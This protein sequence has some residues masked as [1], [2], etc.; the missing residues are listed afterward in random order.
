MANMNNT[1]DFYFPCG[2]DTLTWAAQPLSSVTLEVDGVTLFSLG[3]VPYGL[4]ELNDLAPLITD[5]MKT[6]VP[7]LHTLT[8]SLDDGQTETVK[9]YSIVKCR[10]R[11]LQDAP[12]FTERRFLT[13]ARMD[14]YPKY[15]PLDGKEYLYIYTNA[16]SEGV[17]TLAYFT[18]AY[19]NETLG[20]KRVYTT[21]SAAPADG[22]GED[23]TPYVWTFT[24]NDL[25]TQ[26]DRPDDTLSWRLLEVTVRVGLRTAHYVP[27]DR[28]LWDGPVRGF[29]FENA[30]GLIEALWCWGSATRTLKPSYSQTYI[31]GVMTTYDIEAVPTWE[32]QT[33]MFEDGQLPLLDDFLSSPSITRA[34]D[35]VQVVV[36]E[37]NVKT[38]DDY[39]DYHT[40]TFT[41]REAKADAVVPTDDVPG[42][43]VFDDTFDD[44][45]E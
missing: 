16:A 35:G 34:E 5:G 31:D 44:T 14:R 19:Y 41:V 12:A 43:G 26:A 42:S 20:V 21:L 3:S 22:T 15:V 11:L 7:G 37:A 8:L 29:Y 9:E 1:P 23:G 36:T 10:A 40:A 32:V 4:D 28:S 25:I 38:S 2:L 45:F 27:R 6:L 13:L 39:S 24:L 18:L 30:F 17:G 33:G